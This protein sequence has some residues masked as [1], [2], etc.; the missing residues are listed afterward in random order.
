MVPWAGLG[1]PKYRSGAPANLSVTLSDAWALFTNGTAALP[2]NLQN[3]LWAVVAPLPLQ[4]GSC[5]NSS[6]SSFSPPDALQAVSAGAALDANVTTQVVKS[7]LALI[8]AY[9]SPSSGS[10]TSFNSALADA[11]TSLSLIIPVLQQYG[12][13]ANT[14]SISPNAALSVVSFL[15]DILLASNTTGGSTAVLPLIARAI[16]ALTG[17]LVAN[18]TELC[19]QRGLDISAPPLFLAASCLAVG[20]LKDINRSAINSSAPAGV[21]VSLSDPSSPA[22]IAAQLPE[23]FQLGPGATFGSTSQLTNVSSA[24]TVLLTTYFLPYDPHAANITG[25]EAASLS[26]NPSSMVHLSFKDT[27]TGG[28]VAIADLVHPIQVAVQTP[29][30]PIPRPAQPGYTSVAA[31][32]MIVLSGPGALPVVVV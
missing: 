14:A 30:V 29:P 26:A 20:P 5:L 31:S 27:S 16:D 21:L 18:A 8:S 32:I 6:L 3:G 19:G 22:R 24:G 7:I 1:T 11:S 17:A 9:S 2:A 15:A 25:P 28:T 12:D 10:I 23:T 4:L 13:S